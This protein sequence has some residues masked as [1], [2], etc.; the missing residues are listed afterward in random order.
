MNLGL[1][2]YKQYTELSTLHLQSLLIREPLAKEMVSMCQRQSGRAP[3]GGSPL[4]ETWRM[5]RTFQVE[6]EGRHTRQG[7]VLGPG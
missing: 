2:S 1:Y 5:I 6:K 7:R 4:A 3:G